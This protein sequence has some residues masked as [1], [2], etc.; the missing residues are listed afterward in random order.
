MFAII[1]SISDLLGKAPFAERST[2]RFQSGC[3]D[4]LVG[5][6]RIGM[7]NRDLNLSSQCHG[8]ADVLL[9]DGFIP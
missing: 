9:H 6:G 5:N 2:Y 1:F 4:C 8:A 7:K 3:I